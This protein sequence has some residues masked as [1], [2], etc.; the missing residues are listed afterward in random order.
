[1]QTD[2]KD[3]KKGWNAFSFPN[4]EL[5]VGVGLAVGYPKQSLSTNKSDYIS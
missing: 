5:N 4:T 2:L 3:N 1:M